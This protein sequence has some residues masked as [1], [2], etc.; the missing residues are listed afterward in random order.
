MT[1]SE[2]EAIFLSDAVQ[3][4][5]RCRAARLR[6]VIR[7]ADLPDAEQEIALAVWRNLPKYNPARG[8]L[9]TFI[10]R[11]VDSAALVELRRYRRRKRWMIASAEEL[12]EDRRRD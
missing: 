1:A 9:S 2:A 8:M 6:G 5:I 11:V 3:T 4:S 12:P 10:R 7:L